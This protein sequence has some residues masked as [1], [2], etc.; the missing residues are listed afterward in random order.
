MVDACTCRETDPNHG[1]MQPLILYTICI[2]KILN[3]FTFL[4]KHSIYS[5][6]IQFSAF[7]VTVTTIFEQFSL[8]E[9]IFASKNFALLFFWRKPL[10]HT[11]IEIEEVLALLPYVEAGRFDEININSI[12]E[13]INKIDLLRVRATRAMSKDDARSRSLW[14]SKISKLAQVSKNLQLCYFDGSLRPQPFGI[15]I[16][17]PPGCGKSCSS[18]MIAQ[19]LCES[20]GKPLSKTDLVILNESDEFQSEY[21]TN[22]RVVIFDD[23]AATKTQL[24]STNPYRKLIDFIN[25]IRKSSLNPHLELKGNIQIQPEIV[26]CTM[27]RL[28]FHSWLMEPM[29]LW[30]RF[31]AVIVIRPD[32][33]VTLSRFVP[34]VR[35]DKIDVH[36]LDLKTEGKED[37]D[38]INTDAQSFKNLDEFIPKLIDDFIEHRLDQE[39][40][41]DFYN[42][43][44][45]Q[46]KTLTQQ[47]QHYYDRLKDYWFPSKVVAHCDYENCE[48]HSGTEVKEP[49]QTISKQEKFIAK[50]NNLLH[51]FRLT[52][53]M[54]DSR[55]HRRVSE[56]NDMSKILD[57]DIDSEIG[58]LV[59]AHTH[60]ISLTKMELLRATK[61]IIRLF[62]YSLPFAQNLVREAAILDSFL[63]ATHWPYTIEWRPDR[64]TTPIDGLLWHPEEGVLFVIEMKARSTKT[65]RSKSRKQ[66]KRGLDIMVSSIFILGLSK[67][68]LVG[69]TL[70][71]QDKLIQISGLR[72][73]WKADWQTQCVE[74]LHHAAD[75]TADYTITAG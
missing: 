61:Y 32:R 8:L 37:G 38:L 10:D 28:S 12:N 60:D 68:R 70:F 50:M 59:P 22:H 11:L 47:L 73:P 75:A 71:Y 25:N 53:I 35:Y 56:L 58:T 19:R 44:F 57:V 49:I 29:A 42:Q 1:L 20:I 27:N 39:E 30:R 43:N 7:M 69:L 31:K 36:S 51:D 13:Y 64:H 41:I 4:N 23:V 45:S 63:Q 72:G 33:K 34:N 21:R 5:T 2:P 3:L 16:I 62:S 46:P 74:Y 55:H 17:G 65:A 6:F 67:I 26:I 24:D 15:L 40:F 14:L 54:D 48:P 52:S 9:Q 18:V 66:L